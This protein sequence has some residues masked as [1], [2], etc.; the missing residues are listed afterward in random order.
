[1]KK[2]FLTSTA[3]K[4]LDKFMELIDYPSST[5]T[6]GFIPTAAD[7]YEDKYFVDNDRNK[8]VELGFKLLDINIAGKTEKI[9][10]EELKG[11]DILFIAGGN[12]FYLLEKTLLSGFDNIIRKHVENG[13]WYVGSSAGSVLVGPSIE[14]INLL[15]DPRHAPNL[16]TFDGLKLIDKIILPHYGKEKYQDK[17][18]K[19]LK[20][21]SYLQ[22]KIITLTDDQALMVDG[23][24]I[25]VISS[26]D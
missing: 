1:M 25:I 7:V 5:I 9:L 24:K 10:E 15:D 22:D 21:Y 17:M 20:E 19:I 12:V 4:V 26:D 14:P 11:V 6:V 2:L 13:K 8:L 16:T 3:Y 23:D 18:N